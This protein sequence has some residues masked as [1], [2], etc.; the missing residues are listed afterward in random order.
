MHYECLNNLDNDQYDVVITTVPWTDSNIPLMAPAV[1][2]PIVE[3]AGYSCLAIDANSEVYNLTKTH[4]HKNELV[5][6]FFNENL[7]PVVKQ[8]LYEIFDSLA[9]QII[10]LK[11]KIIGLSL[12]S[13]VCQ[14][15]T[16][17]LSYF[18]KKLDPSV[19]IVI[20]GPGCLDTFT[21]PSDFAKNLLDQGLVDFH[22]RGDGE[23]SFY[24]FLKG[25]KTY[26]GIN[27]TDWTELNREDLA[28]L[29]MPDYS[30]Y[31][32]NQYKKK[33]L[34]IVGSRGCVRKCTFCDYIANWPNFHW[35]T[36]DDIFEEMQKQYEK[37]GIRY[38]KFQ[39]SLTNGNQKEFYKLTQILGEHNLS[40][41][42]DAFRWNGYYI[43]REV[44]PQSEYEWQLVKDSGATSL[45]VGIENLNEHIRY[46]I[47]KKFSNAS[48]DFHLE[49]A[50]KHQ[51]QLQLLNI[52]GYVNETEQDID[53][54]KNWLRTHTKY[55]DD[56]VI[57]WG[58]TLGVFPNTWLAKNFDNLGLEKVG[59]SP[60]SWTNLKTGSTPAKRAKWAK[61]LMTLSRDLG[62]RVSDNI[63]NHY[64]LELLIDEK[65]T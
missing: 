11:P 35:R 21:G 14:H 38:F 65:L 57:Q 20:G 17:W 10:K 39:D 12:L 42:D 37:Y 52:V 48:I 62:Y 1:L 15:A 30:N 18:L 22:I 56:V 49:Q 31:K 4:P 36:A 8:D 47:G 7:N 24:E 32:F 58:G 61:D 43:F 63:D 3:K 27:S 46:D 34:P 60:Q 13:Y 16:R 45:T 6:F 29:P 33:A 23:H 59:T 55:K 28:K 54:I 19:Q 64:L 51:I 40:N 41:P 9:N 5:D 25:N 50:Q 44:T 53:F 2:S 26:S